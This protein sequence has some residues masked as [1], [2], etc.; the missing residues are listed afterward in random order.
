MIKLKPLMKKINNN[1]AVRSFICWLAAFLVKAIHKTIRWEKIGLENFEPFWKEDKPVLVAVWHS[2]LLMM[3]PIWN[4]K[5]PLHVVISKHRDGQLISE[6][7]SHFGIETIEGSTTRGGASALRKITE[8]INKGYSVGIT[9][10]GPKG[11]RMR[12]N[13]KLIHLAQKLDIPIIPVTHSANPAKIFKSWDRFLLAMPFSKGVYIVGKPIIITKD[14]DEKILE[15]K[16]NE[17][18]KQADVYIGINP[19][20][21]E[22]R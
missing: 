4:H 19:I 10:D 2:R 8:T 12:D 17:L 13:S 14:T 5:K 3:P 18:T 1:K 6:T 7:A 20:E 21:P 16:L 9:P 11:P 22:K 15:T